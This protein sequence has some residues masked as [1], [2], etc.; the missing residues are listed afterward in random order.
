MESELVGVKNAVKEIDIDDMLHEFDKKDPDKRRR[1]AVF[2]VDK[3]DK[4]LDMVRWWIYTWR[5]IGLDSAD[6]G[7]DLVML[8]HP[9]AVSKLPGDC[10]LVSENYRINFTSPGQCLYKPYLGIAYRDK[11]YDPYMNSQE[12]LYG[13]GSEFLAQYTLLLRAPGSSTGGRRPSLSTRTTTPT[14]IWTASRMRSR[15]WPARLALTTRSG[16]TR[17]PPGTGTR[18]G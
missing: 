12:C 13:P 5:F 10:V 18:G 9:A 8:T 17:A 4:G 7:F 1:A 15:R 3:G 11:T 14:S 16:I 2:Y 6:Q